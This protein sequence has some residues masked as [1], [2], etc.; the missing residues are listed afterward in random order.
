MALPNPSMAFIPFAILT[1]D[2]LNNF[3]ENDQALAAGTGLN[4][5]AVS[6]DKLATSAIKLGKKTI[7]TSAS[8]TSTTVVQA[9]GLTQAVT[10]PA[11]GRDVKVTVHGVTVENSGNNYVTVSVWD[12][13]VGSGTCIGKSTSLGGA[14][15]LDFVATH[16]PSSGSHTY[17]VGILVTA[18]TG[19]ITATATAGET[20]FILVELT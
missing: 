1:A 6:G 11:G 8:T 13:T 7:T 4:T 15:P 3:V 10:V 18:G 5:N 14:S 9:T 20:A 16:T 17:N 2:E 12:G 19:Y